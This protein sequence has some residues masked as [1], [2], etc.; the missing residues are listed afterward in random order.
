MLKIYL[1]MNPLG[2]TTTACPVWACELMHGLL[3]YGS[4]SL[5]GALLLLLQE[6][7]VVSF[8][9]DVKETAHTIMAQPAELRAH[10]FVA[11][12]L[13]R[14]EM[15]RNNHSRHRVLLKP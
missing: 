2:S 13:V 7:L 4:G 1:L 11:A 5:G 6:S 9:D 10:N 14:G 8:G 3:A 15:N 12:D